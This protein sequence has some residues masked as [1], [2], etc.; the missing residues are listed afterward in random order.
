MSATSGLP[1]S[2]SAFSR[3]FTR[4]LFLVSLVMDFHNNMQLSATEDLSFSVPSSVREMD[5][6]SLIQRMMVVVGMFRYMASSRPLRSCLPTAWAII[7]RLAS[8]N[9]SGSRLVAGRG[10]AEDN[11]NNYNSVDHDYRHFMSKVLKVP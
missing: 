9:T 11:S 6:T 7:V 8:V 5:V 3:L 1:I 2:R 10:V 4:S